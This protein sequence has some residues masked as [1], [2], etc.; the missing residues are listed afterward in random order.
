MDAFT[1]QLVVKK[2]EGKEW[3]MI[4]L[5]AFLAALTLL[6]AVL[7][8]FYLPAF[9]IVVLAGGGYG[10][11]QLVIRQNIEFEYSVTNGDID[12]DRIVARRSR[13]RL[14]SVAGRKLET[15]EPY[16]PDSLRNQSFSRTVMA[17]P[18]LSEPDLWMFS[19]HSKKNGHTLVIFQPNEKV[20]RELFAGLPR[21]LALELKQRLGLF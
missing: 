20:R 2:K 14:V 17:A 4:V 12:I 7:V 16:R 10:V 9:S 8:F 6:A 5:A 15:L 21:P 11:F 18:S 1:E 3:G 19:Y 13:K